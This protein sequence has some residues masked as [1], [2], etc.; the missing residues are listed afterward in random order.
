VKALEAFESGTFD[1]VLM[2]MQM[3][4]MDGLKA[5]QAIRALELTSNLPRT[6]IAMLSAN[7][8]KEH[9]EQALDAGCDVHIAKPVTPES[10]AKGIEAALASAIS[11]HQEDSL[12]YASA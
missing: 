5:T 9:V 1:V 4:E 6:P 3:P 7:A 12:T 2:D 11:T 10:L 8:M